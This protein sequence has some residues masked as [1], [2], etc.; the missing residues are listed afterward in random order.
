MRTMR[1]IAVVL[2]LTG[3]GMAQRPEQGGP[4]RP[5]GF[6]GAQQS[7]EPKP[8][9]KVITAEAKTRQGV[10]AVHQIKDK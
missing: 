10:F 9:D 7:T 6:P 8:Y 3:L 1:L 2:L 5:G 4:Q